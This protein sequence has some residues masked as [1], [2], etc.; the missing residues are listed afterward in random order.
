MEENKNR[1]KASVIK[2]YRMNAMTYLRLRMKQTFS[3]TLALLILKWPS[4]KNQICRLPFEDKVNQEGKNNRLK[5][6]SI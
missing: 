6:L 1:F 4:I 5:L 2:N 3:L